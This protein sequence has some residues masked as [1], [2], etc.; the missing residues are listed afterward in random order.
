M[1]DNTKQMAAR[2][3]VLRTHQT[4]AE[5]VGNQSLILYAHTT[6]HTHTRVPLFRPEC[7]VQLTHIVEENV[8]DDAVVRI[9]KYKADA[10]D[11]TAAM[12]FLN[13]GGGPIMI[14]WLSTPFH[15]P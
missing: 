5:V 6:T 11:I 8:G 10:D 14:E 4:S 12:D 7:I 15:I 3:R 2:R 1:T 13:G 9:L